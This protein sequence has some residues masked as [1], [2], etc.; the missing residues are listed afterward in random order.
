[1]EQTLASVAASA[2]SVLT[3][4]LVKG[5]D[6]FARAAG[7]AALDKAKGILGVL[8]A[9]WAGDDYAAGTL[10][11]YEAQPERYRPA[12]EDV[13]TEQLAKDQELA[14][15]IRKQ[16][17]EIGPTLQII[18]KLDRGENVTGLEADELASGRV[19]VTQ[20]IKEAKDVRGATIKRIG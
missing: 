19:S 13:L 9:K 4:Y 5:A 12:V 7:E 16:L 3:P 10:A 17:A 8:K 11:R 20:E 1:M 15:A 18:Q 6:E 14:A 2:L